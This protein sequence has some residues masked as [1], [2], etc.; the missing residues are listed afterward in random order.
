M[1]ARTWTTGVV[2][3]LLVAGCSSSASSSGAAAQASAVIASKTASAAAADSAQEAITHAYETFFAGTTPAATKV[4]L[5]QNGSSYAGVI[6][7]QAS[8]PTAKGTSAKVLRV[9]EVTAGSTTATV[10]YTVSV[11]G[12]PALSN[13]TGQAVSE[14]GTWKVADSSFCALL[15][16]EGSKV[17]GCPAG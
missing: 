9:G 12:Q 10:T 8:S 5:L 16:L 3:C 17:P 6:Q 1:R 13:Q 7:L 4:S 14:N 2:A 11:N 15:A